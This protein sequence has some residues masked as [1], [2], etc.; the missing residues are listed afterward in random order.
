MMRASFLYSLHSNGLEPG[1]VAD[2][3]KFKEVYKSK[4]GKVRIY[5]LLDV[6]QESEKWVADPKNRRCD[7]PGSWVCRGQYPPALAS[8]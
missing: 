8:V 3:S 2:P 7:V 5:Q 4:Y 1:V 6:D